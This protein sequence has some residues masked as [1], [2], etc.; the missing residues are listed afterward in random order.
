MYLEM[1][2]GAVAGLSLFLYG[3]KLMADGLQKFAGDKLKS[4]VRTLT[5]NRL[6]AVLVGMFVTMVIQ[7]SSA[8]SVMVVG[9]VNASIMTIEQA[10][11]VIFGANIGTTITGQMVSFNLSQWAPIAIGTGIL[12]GAIVKNPKMKELAEILVGFGILF[13]GMNYLKDA[14]APLKDLPAFTEW[15]VNYGH[16]PLFG[17]ALGFIMT[18]ALQSSSATIGVLIALASQGVLP[19][20][21]ALYIIF[22]DN[23]GTCTTALISSLGT[24]RRGKQVAV[25][26][27]SI[28]IIGTIYFMLFLTGILTNIVTSMDA[29]DVAR[30]I[31]NA[32]TLFNIVNVIVLFPFANVLLK[33]ADF[34]IPE[35][36]VE[37]MEEEEKLVSYLDKRILVTPSIALQNT[38]YEFAAMSHAADKT[39]TYAIDAIRLRSQEKIEKAFASEQKVNQFQKA[40]VEYLV[41]ISQQN[42]STTDQETIDELF[43]TANDV[44]R[45]SDHAENIADFA[46]AVLERDI[47]LDEKTLSEL[48]HV[49]ELVQK[50]FAMSIDTLSTGNIE[51]VKEVITIEREIDR[52]KIEIRDKY[53]KRMNK[54]I[55]SAD[56]GIFVMDLLS[57]LER[58]SDHFRNIGETVQRLG[59][60]VV[61][62]E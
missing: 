53:M 16:N 19:F 21:T 17:V 27:L 37:T 13:I 58:I 52:L 60:P 23:I 40:I 10:V 48:E 7:S 18:L 57:N 49:F 9:F 45:I 11:G 54:G 2:L 8:T 28:N 30:Q 47:V 39:L 4:I 24:S 50:G 3:M 51:K 56:S 22:G 33:L 43:S 25:I 14:L 55:A 26:H 44:E 62:T 1:F 35:P 42:V 6:M 29:T 34:I 31:A 15:I 41:E 32:H 46:K 12:M 20:T 38:M 59:R 5:K 61:V 36:Q